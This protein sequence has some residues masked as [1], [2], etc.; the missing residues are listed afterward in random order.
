LRE[1]LTE[2]QR[3]GYIGPGPVDP[4]LAHAHRFAA[5]LEPEPVGR[6]LDL[7]SGGGLPGL[8]LAAEGSGR[9]DWTL[10]D[11]NKR[12]CQFL[13]H[14]L[15]VLGLTDTAQVYE[16]R[17]EIAGRD[18]GLRATF[19]AVVARAFG[20]PAVVAECA[21]PFLRQ[22]GVLV[23]SEPPQNGPT[24]RWPAEGLGRLGLSV[25]DG[26]ILGFAR[27]RQVAPCPDRFPRRVGIPAKRP[28]F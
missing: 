2:A 9:T 25:D 18:P 10:L 12:R 14:A 28:L 15:T 27:L 5:A 26:Q 6:A 8:V 11:A 13:R 1:L 7:G 3:L 19:D 16:G 22:D 20:G 17:A 24:C 23:V 21:A 4:H